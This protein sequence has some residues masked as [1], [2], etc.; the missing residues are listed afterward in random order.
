MSTNGF[1]L[2]M[3]QGQSITIAPSADF[4]LLK[5]GIVSIN[6]VSDDSHSLSF[7][8]EC[9]TQIKAPSLLM[10]GLQG[11][12][13]STNYQ[14]VA[15]EDSSIQKLSIEEIE[16]NPDSQ[17]GLIDGFVAWLS[18]L[19]QLVS[20]PPRKPKLLSHQPGTK[21]ILSAGESFHIPTESLGWI[22]L[23]QGTLQLWH[24]G[25]LTFTSQNGPIPVFEGAWYT[26]IG[27]GGAQ[28]HFDPENKPEPADSII[29]IGSFLSPFLRLIQERIKQDN[30][31]GLKRLATQSKIQANLRNESILLLQEVVDPNQRQRKSADPL[32]A[33]FQLIGSKLDLNFQHPGKSEDLN[34]VH[35]VE[36]VCRASRLR[37]RAVKLR[38]HWLKKDNGPLLAF[39]NNSANEEG[40]PDPVVLLPCNKVLGTYRYWDPEQGE[41]KILSQQAVNQIDQNALMFYRP[42]PEGSRNIFD[43]SKWAIA[44]Y[45]DNLLLLI[46]ISLIISTLG[47]LTPI[48]FGQMVDKAIPDGDHRML[49]EM[50]SCLFA[51][52]IGVTA[53]NLGQGFLTTRV[54]SGVTLDM[55][56]AIM[57]RLLNLPLR[58]FKR[59][60]S[61]DLLNRAMIV[62]EISAETSAVAVKGIFAGFAASISLILLFYYQATL[63]W[64]PLIFGGII[65]LVSFLIGKRVRQHALAL[66]RS[67]GR[68]NGFLFQMVTNI[69][70]FRVAGAEKLIFHH[71]AQKYAEQLR[72]HSGII[73]LNHLNKVLGPG[74]SIIATTCLFAAVVYVLTQS[75]QNQSNPVISMGTFVAFN[76]AF[77]QFMM[78]INLLC[79][80]A[81]DIVDSLAK[82][83]I[84]KPI[85]AADPEFD[86]SKE[87]PGKLRGDIE[88]RNIVFRYSRESP[89]ILNNLSLKVRSGQ[90]VAIVGPSGCGKSTL[91]RILLGF[92]SPQSGTVL[93]D[94]R[95]CAGLDFNFIR[96]QIGTV[97]Q[98]SYISAGSIF[99]NIASGQLINLDE[100]WNAASDSGLDADI[101]AMPMGMHTLVSEGGSNLSG[102]Q[103]QRLLIARAL[104]TNPRVLLFDEATSALDNKTQAIVSRSVSKRNVTRLVIAHRL[105]T[106][107]DADLIIVLDEGQVIQSGSYSELSQTPGMFQRMIARQTI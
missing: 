3:E 78:G 86:D 54:K 103:R 79:E 84:A 10:P 53:F 69:S 72:F 68:M 51:V 27:E 44:S 67:S 34:R 32:W 14:V 55:Q 96:R 101:K 66:E 73:G 97:L 85:I 17:S 40:K 35:Y 6:A 63:A 20:I 62:S 106:I 49:W 30:D 87:D 65:F 76:A 36:A 4:L 31:Q 28:F 105:S 16:I 26:A 8:I 22:T 83:D 60:S 38:N 5:K 15:L 41:F 2:E 82:Q 94:N 12:N 43:L 59:F 18:Y 46:T 42:Y 61:G 19:Q 25:E 47:M 70:K 88:F 104:V 24:Q 95:D 29:A 71:W 33:C 99:E 58:F 91:F 90:F 93:F 98:S 13:H 74:L 57:D 81:V 45:K 7:S 56:A 89:R 75:T 92:E 107:E 64:V 11:E 48:F 37:Y 39:R 9:L 21:Q 77:G 50:A 80:T 100:A 102:G 1:R 52:T 23:T